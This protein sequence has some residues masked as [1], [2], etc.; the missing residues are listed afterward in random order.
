MT[1]G[2]L[3]MVPVTDAAATR[4][5]IAA[6]LDTGNKTGKRCTTQAD[7]SF[8]ILVTKAGAGTLADGRIPLRVKEAKPLPSSD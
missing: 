5:P 8:E 4:Q 1:C 2:G 6:G 3:Q 7:S